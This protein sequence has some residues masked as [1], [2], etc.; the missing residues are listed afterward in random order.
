MARWLKEATQRHVPRATLPRTTRQVIRYG[1]S[2]TGGLNQCGLVY[3]VALFI[4]MILALLC[5]LMLMR[6]LSEMRA[7][8]LSAAE[9]ATFQLAEAGVDQAAI[10]LRTPT[11][12][13]DD[14]TAMA[15][16]EG[17][18]T[19]DA[20]PTQL[21]SQWW[22]V[23]AHGLSASQ[24]GA[25]RSI[26]AVFQ[27]VPL[28]VFQYGLF[29]DQAVNVSGSGTTNSYDSRVG[30]YN[31]DSTSPGYNVTHHGDVGT[32][33]T[34]TTLSHGI[35]ISGSISIDGQVA[36]GPNVPNPTSVVTGY[37]SATITGNPKVVSQANSFPMPPV[38]I[39]P[40]LSCND[41]T[42][43]E[44]SVVTL[45]S[46]GGANGD[47]NYCYRILTLQ[48]GGTLT[49]DGPVKIYLTEQLAARGHSMLGVPSDP[50]KVQVL[51]S[52]SGSASLENETLTGST[53][54]YGTLYGPQATINITGN[55]TVYGSVI[56]RVVNLSGSAD[57]HYDQAL[58]NSNTFSNL[59][60]TTLISWRER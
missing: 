4:V 13:A 26:E 39:P 29:G 24:A 30:A 28:S 43:S 12:L 54:F 50:T 22:Q 48:G 25:Q 38:V 7:S 57:I 10:N 46:V 2:K 49:A 9:A 6:S 36:V 11:S 60:K 18:V 19:I 58:G 20:P 41:L 40:S 21:T 55:A 52:S 44:H 16:P 42:V 56:A 17:S 45:S 37:N 33:A 27:V 3:L 1:V 35:W 14:I 5:N 53:E 15:L 31:D 51:I 32:N 23:V 8:Q 34:S 59:N 47:G